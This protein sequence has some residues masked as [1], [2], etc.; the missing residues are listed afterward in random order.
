MLRDASEL[1][2]PAVCQAVSVL[3]L[4]GDKDA[5]AVKLAKQ[6]ARTIDEAPPGKE[7]YTRL[8][9]LGPELLKLLESLGATPAARAAIKRGQAPDKPAATVSKLDRL[10]AASIHK[11]A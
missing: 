6:Y 11:P 8:R 4:D 5:A 7:Y 2:Y 9:W 3:D 10:R 1:L